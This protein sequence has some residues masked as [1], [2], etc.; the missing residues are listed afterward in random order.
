MNELFDSLS[1]KNVRLIDGL[2]SALDKSSFDFLE[3][4]SGDVHL[5]IGKGTPP[6]TGAPGG[7]NRMAGMAQMVTAEAA[8]LSQATPPAAAAAAPEDAAPV[9]TTSDEAEPGAVAVR[10]PTI[11]RFYS[12]P[13]PTAE[14]FVSPGVV[15]AADSTIGLIEVMKLFNA[16]E[17]GV[18]GTISQILVEDGALVEHGQILMT[19]RPAVPGDGP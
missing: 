15:V 7:Q 3:L 19:I 16:I 10:A 14:P 4:R 6:A 11:G 13:E 8:P 17:A 1:E 9:V 5:S 2:V 12:R 18:A